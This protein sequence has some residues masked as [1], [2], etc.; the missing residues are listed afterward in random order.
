MYKADDKHRRLLMDPMGLREGSNA[1]NSPMVKENLDED[2]RDE[3]MEA[4]DASW[5]RGVVAGANYLAHDRMD[6]QFATKK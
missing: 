3:E 1:V 2:G 4:R 6:L 5:F